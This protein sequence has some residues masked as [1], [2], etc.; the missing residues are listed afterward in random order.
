MRVTTV[1]TNV[2]VLGQIAVIIVI[3]ILLSHICYCIIQCYCCYWM[4]CVQV[5][6]GKKGSRDNKTRNG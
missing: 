1:N 6:E 4:W 2:D 3:S 5:T